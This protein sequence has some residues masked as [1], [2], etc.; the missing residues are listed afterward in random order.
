MSVV[1]H[2][3]LAIGNNYTFKQAGHVVQ[4]YSVMLM[5]C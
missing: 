3:A 4:L 5:G 2:K 1:F